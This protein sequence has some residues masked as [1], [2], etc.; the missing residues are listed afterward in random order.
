MQRRRQAVRALATRVVARETDSP[1]Y[2]DSA[3]GDGFAVVSAVL[4]DGE[5]VQRRADVTY[6]DARK[7]LSEADLDAKFADCCAEARIAPAAARR[8]ATALRAVPASAS[9]DALRAALAR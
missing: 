5:R 2:G 9:L 8:L 1:P 7:P 6:G 4:P 3:Y